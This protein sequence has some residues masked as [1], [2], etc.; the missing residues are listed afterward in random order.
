MTVVRTI[1]A[2]VGRDEQPRQRRHPP[3]DDAGVR[4]EAVVGQAIP[5]GKVENLD[6]RRE[7]ADGA[8]DLGEALPVARDEHDAGGRGPCRIGKDASDEP[9]GNRGE[10]QGPR[11]R[12]RRGD[13]LGLEAGIRCLHRIHGRLQRVAL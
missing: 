11:L 13:S 7:E 12:Q 10:R 3:G 4:R 6:L 9:V 5:G 8:L 2:L 1:A